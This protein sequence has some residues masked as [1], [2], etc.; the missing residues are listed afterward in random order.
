MALSEHTDEELMQAFQSG[1]SEGFDT[2]FNRYYVPLQRYLSVRIRQDTDTS[3]DVCQA[4]FLRVHKHKDRF[5]VGQLFRPWLYAI[6]DRLAK[7]ANRDFHN[8]K[9]HTMR[10]SDF[11]RESDHNEGIAWYHSREC[12]NFTDLVGDGATTPAELNRQ[13]EVLEAL[14]RL[15]LE[16][17]VELRQ[18]TQFVMTNGAS[19]RSAEAILCVDRRVLSK[20]LK[21]ACEI[22]R[23]RL[24]RGDIPNTNASRADIELATV[25]DVID[26]LPVEQ[27]QALHRVVLEDS[28]IGGDVSVLCEVLNNLLGQC[29]TEAALV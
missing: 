9:K 22:I 11:D 16:L 2:L 20:R 15:V 3:D 19:L 4:V 17:P 12:I 23:E 21:R 14:P 18:I 13:A 10:F 25:R 5:Q 7:N 24:D 27:Y 1:D 28:N 8:R 6:A 26:M 29:S